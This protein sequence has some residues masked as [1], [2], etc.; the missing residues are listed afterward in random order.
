MKY[1]YLDFSQPFKGVKT[2]LTLIGLTKTLHL[3]HGLLVCRPLGQTSWPETE[4]WRTVSSKWGPGAP[5]SGMLE[6][7]PAVGPLSQN[8]YPFP[9]LPGSSDSLI[10]KC[11][12][13][14]RVKVCLQGHRE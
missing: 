9:Q 4:R 3:A 8:L 13:Q 5:T 2:I 11:W 7:T 14:V 1:Y 10:S 6:V 12:S